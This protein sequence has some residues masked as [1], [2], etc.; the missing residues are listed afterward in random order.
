MRWLLTFLVVLMQVQ[1]PAMASGSTPMMAEC[2]QAASSLPGT[3]DHPSSHGATDK[4]GPA[5]HLCP[6]CS[7]PGMA[8]SIA[9]HAPA[10]DA[11]LRATRFTAMVSRS[12]PPSTPPPRQA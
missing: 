11:P 5:A 9:I 4:A 3:S 8:P 1:S 7:I 12:D 2:H 10:P 6:G